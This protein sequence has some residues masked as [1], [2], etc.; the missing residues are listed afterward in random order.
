M[1]ILVVKK[2]TCQPARK[3]TY[4]IVRKFHVEIRNEPPFSPT[5]C[6]QTGLCQRS[7]NFVYVCMN[8][9]MNKNGTV[10][11]SSATAYCF[12]L[13]WFGFGLGFLPV[14]SQ[15]WKLFIFSASY[16]GY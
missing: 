16:L 3:K 1:I 9:Q 13:V 5:P 8:I 2:E 10:V 15:L 6:N 14:H 7:R 12:V 11:I 4:L